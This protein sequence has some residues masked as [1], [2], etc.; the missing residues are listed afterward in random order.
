MKKLKYVA[1][2][3]FASVLGL[4]AQEVKNQSEELANIKTGKYTAYIT[5]QE[6]DKYKGGIEDLWFE[7]LR[8]EKFKAEPNS[9]LYE[10]YM[11][12]GESKTYENERIKATL[13]PDNFAFPMTYVSNAYEGNKKLQ[14]KVG[15]IYDP[16]EGEPTTRVVFLD[17]AIYVM[18]DYMDKDNY[19]LEYILEFEEKPIK[20]LKMMKAVMKSP[21]K[22][23]AMQP[24]KKLQAYLDAA[25]VLQKN[26]YA[27][28][29]KKP[30]NI[31]TEK[32]IEDKRAMMKKAIKQYNDDIFNSPEYQ[33]MLA[34]QKWIENSI[35]MT[36]K[37]NKGTT[38]WV[39][40]SATAF[41]TTE[42]APGKSATQNCTSDLYYYYSDAKGAQGTKFYTANNACG[43]TVTIN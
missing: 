24:K 32:Y 10:A 35:N 34:Y 5:K 36:V 31:K 33:R 8:I 2:C 42:I 22:M 21:K 1:L 37:N 16:Y 23:Q 27:S 18:E 30:E 17:G 11:F 20:G 9:G 14:E 12:I 13:L 39:G 26:R 19:K 15:Y 29:I 6:G 41:I 3:L 40:S 43:S 28:W 7:V 25:S 38:V 4:N